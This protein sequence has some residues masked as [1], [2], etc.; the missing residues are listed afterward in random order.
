M[1]DRDLIPDLPPAST[2]R[3]PT[4]AQLA[5]G[6]TGKAMFVDTIRLYLRNGWSLAVCC[7]DCPRIVEWTPPVLAERFDGKLDTTIGDLVGRVACKGE[8]GCGS[9]NI[10]LFPHPYDHDWTWPNPAA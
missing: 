2:L 6:L 3:R 1:T 7:M 5:Q 4:K 9:R 8:G 10:A